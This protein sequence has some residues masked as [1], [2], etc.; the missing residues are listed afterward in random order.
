M[1]RS[2]LQT[3]LEATSAVCK[4]GYKAECF[5]TLFLRFNLAIQMETPLTKKKK[6]NN[7]TLNNQTIDHWSKNI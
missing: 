4:Q 1:E 5:K 6:K 2:N 3:S 7:Q